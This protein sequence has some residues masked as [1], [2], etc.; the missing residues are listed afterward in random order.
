MRKVAE[1]WSPSLNGSHMKMLALPY[2]LLKCDAQIIGR[3]TLEVGVKLY[4]LVHNQRG[5]V[6]SFSKFL[7]RT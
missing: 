1:P 5:L 2:E 7:L 6:R 4:D 3:Q